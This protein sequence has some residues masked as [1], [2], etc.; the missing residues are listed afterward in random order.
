[1]GTIK[2][3]NDL[4]V[5]FD[6]TFRPWESSDLSDNAIE[7]VQKAREGLFV[8]FVSIVHISSR[9]AYSQAPKDAFAQTSTA[10]PA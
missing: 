10:L 7:F 9:Q 6:H 4:C 8:P 5:L 3:G 2:K 1:M